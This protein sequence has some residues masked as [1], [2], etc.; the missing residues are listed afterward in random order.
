[1][2]VDIFNVIIVLYSL[3]CRHYLSVIIY[4]YIPHEKFHLLKQ[5]QKKSLLVHV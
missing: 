4:I 5:Q 1:M 3:G 2:H